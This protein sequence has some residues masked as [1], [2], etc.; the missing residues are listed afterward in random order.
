MI[1]VGI[2]PGIRGG[3]AIVAVEDG[4][5]PRLVAAIDVP[6]IGDENVRAPN[7]GRDETARSF[8]AAL[9]AFQQGEL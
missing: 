6:V 2:D 7:R 3:L 9:E 4:A 5:A 1:V 8:A